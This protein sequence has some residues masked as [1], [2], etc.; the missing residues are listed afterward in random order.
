MS[1]I[2]YVNFMDCILWSNY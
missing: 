2:W 1:T